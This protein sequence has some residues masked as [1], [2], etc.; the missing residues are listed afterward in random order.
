MARKCCQVCEGY[1]G[2]AVSVLGVTRPERDFSRERLGDY[3][4]VGLVQNPT[5]G[6][7]MFVLS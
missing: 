2:V 3:A 6:C 4:L 1:G 7:S 5:P